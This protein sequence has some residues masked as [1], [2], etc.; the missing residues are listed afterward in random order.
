RVEAYMALLEALSLPDEGVGERLRKLSGSTYAFASDEVTEQ[1][2]AMLVSGTIMPSGSEEADYARAERLG[3]QMD[4]LISMIREEI[5]TGRE[6]PPW[7]PP[8][9][10][11][12]RLRFLEKRRAQRA[13]AHAVEDGMKELRAKLLEQQNPQEGF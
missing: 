1:A 11:L 12:E 10:R 6:D 4:S 9:Q 3:I 8:K 13:E 7:R 2:M 5:R